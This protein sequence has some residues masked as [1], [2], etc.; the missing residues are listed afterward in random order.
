VPLRKAW[1]PLTFTDENPPARDNPVAPA[2]R[3]A[4]AQTKASTKHDAAG[5]PV[6]SFHDLLNH[7]AT[8]TRDRIRYHDTDIEIDKLTQPTGTQRR[9]FDLINTPIPLTIAA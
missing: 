6:H 2:Q 7:L 3:S 8:L 9:A 1:T 5:N 4:A